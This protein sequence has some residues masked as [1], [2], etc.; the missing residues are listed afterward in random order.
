MTEN[1]IEKRFRCPYCDRTFTRK[2]W[3]ERH[4]RH[5]CERKR[6]F[7]ERNNIRTVTALRLYNYWM[8]KLVGRKK[9]STIEEFEK[10]Q[11]YKLFLRL[12][13]FCQTNYLVS[14]VRYVDWLIETKKPATR[15]TTV[16]NMKP[17]REWMRNHE[18]PMNQVDITYKNVSQWCRENKI[19]VK[20]FFKQIPPVLALNM[21]Q[22][23]RLLPW[24]LFGYGKSE[25][26]LLPRFSQGIL[27]EMDDFLNAGHWIDKILKEPKLTQS[28]RQECSRLFEDDAS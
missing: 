2:P 20:D 24:V 8:K 13:E 16:Y 23:N 10:A 18:D 22:E 26:E 25:E 9:E 7:L 11:E 14:N 4:E 27:Y 1:P 19:E 6:R 5:V 21:I 15:W 17:Y 3:Y 12:S 28:I